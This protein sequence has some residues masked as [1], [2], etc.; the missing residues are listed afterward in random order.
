MTYY[1]GASH[2]KCCRT[3]FSADFRNSSKNKLTVGDDLIEFI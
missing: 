1:T 3:V 2:E